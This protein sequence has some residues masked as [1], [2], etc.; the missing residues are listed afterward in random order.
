MFYKNVGGQL[1]LGFQSHRNSTVM[2]NLMSLVS[3]G[4]LE[5]TISQVQAGNSVRLASFMP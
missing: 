5:A 3:S 4:T 2:N 1:I